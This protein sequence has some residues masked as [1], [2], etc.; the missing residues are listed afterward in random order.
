MKTIKLFS[1]LYVAFFLVPLSISAQEEKDPLYGIYTHEVYPD[2]WDTEVAFVKEIKAALDEYDVDGLKWFTAATNANEFMYI[3]PMKNMAELDENPW[4]ELV[5]KMGKDKWKAMLDKYKDNK[6]KVTSSVI[7]LNRDITY[8]P[9]GLDS[10][11]PDEN[12]RS[13]NIFYIKP[14][15]MRDAKE[16]AKKI[17]EYYA[18]KNSMYHYRIYETYFGGDDNILY[19]SSSGKNMADYAT[20]AE[21]NYELL[22]EGIV[23][24]YDDFLTHVRKQ[25]RKYGNMRP[26]L[27]R[28]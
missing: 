9:E 16:A 4:A 18:S 14:G 10:G 21:N 11:D 26:D 20:D 19:V 22:G 24:L 17:K 1:L 13:W 5:D 25:E 3:V 2:K 12:F 23:P 27:S 7:S 8:M 15:H 6:A 28:N